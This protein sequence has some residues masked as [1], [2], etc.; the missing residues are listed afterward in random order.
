M[1]HYAVREVELNHMNP[2]LKRVLKDTLREFHAAVRLLG[3]IA[4]KEWDDLKD[5]TSQDQLTRME[6]LVHT[7]KK[8]P[9]KY[10][11]FDTVFY[12]YPSYYRRSAIHAACGQVSSYQTRLEQ[13][14]QKRYETISNGKRFRERPPVLNLETASCPS[15]Y[16]GQMYQKEGCTI[17]L[18]VFIR[19]TWDWITV[20]MPSRD[21]K[22]LDQ[23][24]ASGGKLFSPKLLSRKKKFYLQFPVLFPQSSFP[25]LPVKDRT[26][27]GV[28][29]GINR[30]AVCSVVHASGTVRGRYFDPFVRER[31]R[32]D[33]QLNRLK[34]AG[35]QSGKG[36]TLASCYTKLDGMKKNY[37]RKLA[38]WIVQRAKENQ[39]YG[40]VLE[41]LG[42][43]RGRGRKK[44]RIHHWCK[45]KVFSLVKGM[46]LRYGIRVF[47]INP[48]NTSAL[49][50]DGSGRVTRDPD[51]FSLCTFASGKR[52]DCDL[53]AS[54]NIAARYLIRAFMK[55]LPETAWSQCVAKV[56]ALAKRTD[57][58]LSTLWELY[59]LAGTGK[60]AA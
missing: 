50:F 11:E 13:Y 31:D 37:T 41:H 22:C 60:A 18:K 49:A 55:S 24:L 16:K 51:N 40:I 34:K 33:H 36:Q 3:E 56:P 30:G 46:A 54:Y 15:L 19:N 10:P 53:S 17:Q 5:R 42:K 26:V 57:C 4:R 9:A 25:D 14:Q 1:K 32:I 12:K 28:D 44:D 8:N 35:R 45:R 59:R 48:R 38:H 47:E 6:Q 43:M 23:A 52:Y 20:T 21:R 39:V 58:T 2:G 29:L 27:L 7:T